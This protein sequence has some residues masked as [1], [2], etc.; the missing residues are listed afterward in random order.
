M[1]STLLKHKNFKTFI[2]E[3]CTI[4]VMEN[5]YPL[6]KNL[7][8][9]TGALIYNVDETSVCANAKGKLVVPN[10]MH[11]YVEEDKLIG[12]MIAVLTCSAVG[13]E[14]WW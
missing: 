6:V 4:I 8:Q 7:I 12:Y 5:F 14:L 3:Y 2:K 9:D 10:W 13:E 11:P 1:A